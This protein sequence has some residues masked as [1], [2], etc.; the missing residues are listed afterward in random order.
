[1]PPTFADLQMPFPLFV[2][3]A[4][5]ATGFKPSGTCASC[6]QEGP[7]FEALPGQACYACLRLGRAGIV[8]DSK[9]GMIGPEEAAIGL[10]GGCPGPLPEGFEAVPEPVDPRF[11]EEQWHRFRVEP[12]LL[13]E[14]VRTPRFSSWQGS[15]WQFCCGRPAIFLGCP[16]WERWQALA[17][18]EG[19][20]LEALLGEI[21]GLEPDDAEVMGFDLEERGISTYL[22]RCGSCGRRLGYADRS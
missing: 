21:L 3:P 2:A 7:V 5:D 18:E 12:A 20:E 19:R 4:K 6:G 13:Q 9:L 17:A 16:D 14:L 10:T 1:M 11:P 8:H 22:F 15:V